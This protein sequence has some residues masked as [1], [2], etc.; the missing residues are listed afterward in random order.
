MHRISTKYPENPPIA[1]LAP[2]APT[3]F[4]NCFV[5]LISLSKL[6]I[7]ETTQSV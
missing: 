3:A 2:Y 1:E 4:R 7:L 6:A 5:S